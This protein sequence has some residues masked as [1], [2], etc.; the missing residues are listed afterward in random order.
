MIFSSIIIPINTSFKGLFKASITKNDNSLKMY[1]NIYKIKFPNN[2][3]I[4]TIMNNL[5]NLCNNDPSA[6]K[7]IF[8]IVSTELIDSKELNYTQ[9]EFFLENINKIIK[10]NNQYIIFTNQKSNQKIQ[11]EVKYFKRIVRYIKSF[12]YNYNIINELIRFMITEKQ[13]INLENQKKIKKDILFENI[14]NNLS[15]DTN[16]NNDEINDE[17]I[18]KKQSIIQEILDFLILDPQCIG[19]LLNL[20]NKYYL[21]ENESKIYHENNIIKIISSYIFPSIIT[22]NKNF[23]LSLFDSLNNTSLDKSNLII[24]NVLNYFLNNEKKLK[25]IHIKMLLF[26]LFIYCI[27]HLSETNF[28]WV[29]NNI[30]NII[31]DYKL[32]TKILNYYSNKI[33]KTNLNFEIIND[34]NDEKD[35]IDNSITEDIKNISEE[36]KYLK[37][38]DQEEFIN[39]IFQNLN[40]NSNTTNNTINIG[41]KSILN[42]NNFLK[43]NN[44]TSNN[45]L[46]DIK[47][48]KYKNY[49]LNYNIHKDN[50]KIITQE[51]FDFINYLSNP[52]SLKMVEKKELHNYFNILKDILND[53][54]FNKNMINTYEYYKILEK[55][56]QTDYFS[57]LLIIYKIIVPYMYYYFNITIFEDTFLFIYNLNKLYN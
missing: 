39:K 29:I 2:E 31:Y 27:R 24:K 38:I 15:N 20:I 17:I 45:N 30:D 49:L 55:Y 46:I 37:N 16:K 11:I 4:D 57:Y 22:Y 5:I 8:N 34:L 47:I 36:Y 35:N 48:S 33:L 12:L 23:I 28:N 25:S 50:N 40:N 19:Y 52:I 7:T 3:I 51:F 21:L 1:L 6:E 42:L 26:I 32:Q 13:N 54:N 41:Y 18:V 43:K 44:N 14:N 9:C 56:I 10:N 53:I